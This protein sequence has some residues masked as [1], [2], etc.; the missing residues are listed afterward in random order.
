MRQ[1]MG[2]G[3]VDSRGSDYDSAETERE[4]D[5]GASKGEGPDTDK[6]AVERDSQG[7]R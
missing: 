1:E 4:R 5:R 7:Q 6:E 2:D 3:W